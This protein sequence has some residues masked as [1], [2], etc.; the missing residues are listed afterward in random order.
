MGCWFSKNDKVDDVNKTD[1]QT[2]TDNKN[3]VS[4]EIEIPTENTNSSSNSE[5][6]ET[7]NITEQKPKSNEAS[8]IVNVKPINKNKQ[9]IKTKESKR[10]KYETKLEI[11]ISIKFPKQNN[12]G[13]SFMN[14][15]DEVPISTKHNEQS[16]LSNKSGNG[17]L[18]ES[19]VELS[20]SSKDDKT[21]TSRNNDSLDK[22]KENS[23]LSNKS[24]ISSEN[25]QENNQ[26]DK[27]KSNNQSVKGSDNEHKSDTKLDYDSSFEKESDQEKRSNTNS[28]NGSEDN[29]AKSDLENRS[30]TES[31]ES[32]R[33][34]IENASSNQSNVGSNKELESEEENH[35]NT[36]SPIID[37][38]DKVVNEWKSLIES[39]TSNNKLMSYALGKPRSEFKLVS[40]VGHYLSGC[41]DAKS[42]TEKAW[43]I[44]LWITH[45]IEYDLKSF[46]KKDN[47][48]W[49]PKDVLRR[50]LAVCTGYAELYNTLCEYLEIRCIK[51]SGYSK[52]AGYK[53]GQKMTGENHVWNAIALGSDGKLRFI[54]ITLGVGHLSENR[55]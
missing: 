23:E 53:I 8:Y 6:N 13:T 32:I 1:I 50:G 34:E 44:Y 19:K 3:P 24:F 26:T 47:R 40:E 46:L 2:I 7:K 10:P 29:K 51:I 38:L 5:L 49:K 4:N 43:L 36:N 27:N 30:T 41:E 37:R 11:D 15:Y 52:C 16:K 55:E 42:V 21:V 25:G 18:N 22:Q 39:L 17:K 35:N 12:Y 20:D 14:L 45:N 31:E 9:T 33:T 28:I 54:D 48:L